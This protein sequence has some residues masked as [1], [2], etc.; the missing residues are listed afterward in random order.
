VNTAAAPIRRN[1]FPLAP[2]PPLLRVDGLGHRFG[3]GCGSCADLTGAAAETSRCEACGAIVALED[4][5]LEVAPGEVLAIVGES[6]SGKTTLLRCLNLELRPERGAAILGGVGNLFA[7]DDAGARDARLGDVVLVHQDARAA[8]LHPDLA[9]ESNVGE[10]LLSGGER[11]FEAIR[12][13]ATALL[14]AMEVD[15]ARVTDLLRTFSGGMRQRVQLARALVEPPRLLLLDEPTTGLDP[16]VQAALLELIERVVDDVRGATVI[17][18]HDLRVVR[19]LADRVVV[20]R[21]GRVVEQGVAAQVLED[22]QHPYTRLLVAS[23][24]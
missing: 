14:G 19:L 24:L 4:V 16:S 1:L 5:T 2:P 22:P 12:A 6:G 17:V 18:S 13:R 10:R 20:L 15:A 9:A 23:Q 8:G 3:G 11:S 21:F 7:L